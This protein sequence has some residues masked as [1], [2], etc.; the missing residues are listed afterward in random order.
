MKNIQALTLIEILIAISLMSIIFLTGYL[1]LKEFSQRQ[2]LNNAYQDVLI[3][4]KGAQN[5]AF[6]GE[7]PASCIQIEGYRFEVI[8]SSS[9]TVSA[10]CTENTVIN[11][12]T[13]KLPSE[14]SIQ[15]QAVNFK[16]L[17]QG[18]NLASD[19]NINLTSSKTNLTKTITVSYGG[20]IK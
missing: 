5:K 8:D 19:I 2:V 10:L 20:V 17:G 15:G 12:K 3:N 1:S 4:L 13:Y 14:I 6:S 16:A 9:Y 18:T 11:V 7:K